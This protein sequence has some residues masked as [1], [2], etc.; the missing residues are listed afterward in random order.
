M[1][2]VRRII[3]SLKLEIKQ[4]LFGTKEININSGK[5]SILKDINSLQLDK[6]ENMKAEEIEFHSNAN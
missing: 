1:L 3:Y 5:E 2:Q 4:S 6:I